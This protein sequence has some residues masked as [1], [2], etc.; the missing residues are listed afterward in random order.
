[1]PT[2][3]A[4]EFSR[5][6]ARYQAEAQRERVVVTGQEGRVVGAFLS[7]ED[8]ARYERLLKRERQVFAVEDLPDEVAAAIAAAEYGAEPG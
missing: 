3:A 2:V 5:D 4:S 6:F 1:M 8:L 7:P